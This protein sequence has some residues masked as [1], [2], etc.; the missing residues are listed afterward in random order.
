MVE[1]GP[2]NTVIFVAEGSWQQPL[3]QPVVF[4]FC[5]CFSPRPNELENSAP[6]IYEIRKRGRVKMCCALCKDVV[7]NFSTVWVTWAICLKKIN[8]PRAWSFKGKEDVF[9]G[10][11]DAFQTLA[12][13][14][15]IHGTNRCLYG[16]TSESTEHQERFSSFSFTFGEC[17]A[18]FFLGQSGISWGSASRG[19]INCLS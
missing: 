9:V 3:R 6:C 15:T 8:F 7:H 14:G 19:S 5:F 1:K 12:I 2:R 4:F 17:P 11:L 16:I 13:H 18:F 10:L